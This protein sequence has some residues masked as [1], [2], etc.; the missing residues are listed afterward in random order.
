MKR[1]LLVVAILGSMLA[2]GMQAQKMAIGPSLLW[3]GGVNTGNIPTGLKTGANINL[4]PDIAATFRILLNRDES[5]GFTA[6]LGYAQYTYRMRPESESIANDDNT[7]I[8]KHT[9]FNIAPMFYISG[10]QIG[11]SF[12][13]PLAYHMVRVSGASDADLTT[14]Q[15]SPNIE[16][17]IGGM[18]PVFRDKTGSVNVLVQGG[19]MLT[20]LIDASEFSG[21]SDEFNPKAA[22]FGIGVNYL[23][24][25]SN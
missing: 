10:F 14:K 11:A 13:F 12:G 17:R 15:T 3:K 9:F 1:T 22:S 5:I 21:T 8:S 4:I 25:L 7:T 18:I 20:G 16:L 24:N 6:D 2:T 19:Y 23:F